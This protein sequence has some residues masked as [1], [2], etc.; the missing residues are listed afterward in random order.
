LNKYGLA[1]FVIVG[2]YCAYLVVGALSS[3]GGLSAVNDLNECTEIST[4]D[5]ISKISA[6]EFLVKIDNRVVAET[7]AANV[8]QGSVALAGAAVGQH[9]QDPRLAPALRE[10]LAKLQQAVEA[11]NPP[12]TR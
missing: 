8:V 10:C 7:T 1:G 11:D 3:F 2:G 5:P 6:K 4:R 12:E 9:S